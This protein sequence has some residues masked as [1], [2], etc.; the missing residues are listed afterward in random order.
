MQYNCQKKKN[1]TMIRKTLHRKQWSPTHYTE[2]ND[3]QHTTQKTMITNTLHRKQWSPTHY[4]ENN[5]HQHYCLSNGIFF[6]YKYHSFSPKI[7]ILS[8]RSSKYWLLNIWT[9]QIHL[10]MKF[11]WK[12]KS[13]DYP[14]HIWLPTSTYT[15]QFLHHYL[16]P[17]LSRHW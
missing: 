13:S 14:L 5:D 10:T 3:H 7:M 16:W 17:K 12:R 9:L 1:N 11:H 2:N 8:S 15:L 4:T 6:L